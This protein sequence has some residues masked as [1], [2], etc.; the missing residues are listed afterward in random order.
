MVFIAATAGPSRLPWRAAPR[1]L[2]YIAYR[3]AQ[4]DATIPSTP[5][6]L[7]DG[8]PGSA[9][10]SEVQVELDDKNSRHTKLKEKMFYASEE[11]YKAWLGTGAAG[12]FRT[13]NKGQ[14][15]RW[16]GGDVV[17][18]STQ[19]GWSRE[20]AVCLPNVHAAAKRVEEGEV[21][22]GDIMFARRREGQLRRCPNWG[23]S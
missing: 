1:L 11:G 20:V 5:D 19:S 8:P 22:I 7:T 16:L 12:Q 13:H 18:Y 15:A 9:T 14:K 10:P 2:P 21:F 17:S 3:S 23:C 4:T 6:Q